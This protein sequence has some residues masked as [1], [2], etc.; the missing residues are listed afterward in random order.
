VNGP[1]QDGIGLTHVNQRNGRRWSAAD[2]FLKPAMRR[3]NLT[4]ETGCLVHRIICDGKKTT[5]IAYERGGIVVEVQAAKEI[6]LCAGAIGSPHILLLSGIGPAGT[7][8]E[9]GIGVVADLPGVGQNLQDHIASGCT[10]ECTQPVTLANAESLVNLVRYLLLG[11]GPLTSNIAEALAFVRTRE[12]LAAPDVELI[13]AP[14]YFMEHGAANPPGHGFTIGAVLLR[15]ESRGTIT[16]KSSDARAHPLIRPNYLAAPGDIATL[17]AGVRVA[18]KLAAAPPFA[19]Y[20][21]AEVWPGVERQTDAQLSEFM[22]GR[23]ET[24]YHPVGTCKMG[25]D[26][27]A[28]VDDKLRVRGI[29]RLRVADASIMPTIIGGHT[30]APAVMIG[31]KAADLIRAAG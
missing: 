31:E 17:L 30:H 15:P 4:V 27:K 14:A 12:G 1:I 24:L 18:R 21:G 28:V 9:H 10:F 26:A 23:V 7:L 16:L 8:A 22:R 2:A 29:E 3:P 13:F 19:P 6:I 11:R 5:G 25:S 20:R